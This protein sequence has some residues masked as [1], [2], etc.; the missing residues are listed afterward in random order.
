M[1]FP[2]LQYAIQG[3]PTVHVF[4][5]VIPVDLAGP[6]GEIDFYALVDTGSDVSVHLLG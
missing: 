6:D 1:I 5:P 2:Y 3:G 4:R